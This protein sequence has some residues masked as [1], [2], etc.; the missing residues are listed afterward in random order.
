MG[1]PRKHH[2][3]PQ[4]LLRGFAS[5][6]KGDQYYTHMFRHDTP[7]KEVNI[8]N[9]GQQRDFHGDPAESELEHLMSE[10][11]ARYAPV[12]EE[13][14]CGN[15]SNIETL[16]E[17]VA[18]LITRTRNLRLNFVNSTDLFLA[19]MQEQVL[20]NPCKKTKLKFKKQSRKEI[21][22]ALKGRLAHL[23]PHQRK[24]AK[25]IFN[26]HISG[27]DVR[28][29]FADALRGVREQV[30][31]AKI[32]SKS[33][34]ETLTQTQAPEIRVAKLGQLHWTTDVRL[35]PTWILGVQVVS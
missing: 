8:I 5:Q 34:I 25:K 15:I 6:V 33:Q 12:V 35:E 23:H 13:A 14:R 10:Q 24:I 1:E 32:V 30:D 22:K 26:K 21:N 31:L 29:L 7:P 2:F 27:V 16:C 9:V 28:P 20:T 3:L 11:E 18:N 17:F 19:T 4:F